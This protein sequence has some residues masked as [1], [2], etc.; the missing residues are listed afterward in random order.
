MS[1]LP[2]AVFKECIQLEQL[3]SKGLVTLSGTNNGLPRFK[4]QHVARAPAQQRSSQ[5][6]DARAA[7]LWCRC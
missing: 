5:I 4:C 2:N 3:K 1:I 7:A 6:L